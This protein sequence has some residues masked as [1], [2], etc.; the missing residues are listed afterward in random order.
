MPISS[1]ISELQQLQ[2][3]LNEASHELAVQYH[4]LEEA[5]AR[6]SAVLEANLDCLVTIDAQ[7]RVVDFNPAAEQTFGYRRE[8][9]LGVLM[10]DL[11]VPRRFVRPIK[12]AW[13]TI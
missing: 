8:E 1:R 10:A 5:R 9:T 11:I 13:R 12:R 2:Q 7:G 6:K 3:A 4:Q